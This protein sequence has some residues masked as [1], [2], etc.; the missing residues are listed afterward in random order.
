MVSEGEKKKKKTIYLL[1]YSVS[2]VIYKL[3]CFIS[4]VRERKSRKTN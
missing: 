1:V 2:Y 4:K 3:L